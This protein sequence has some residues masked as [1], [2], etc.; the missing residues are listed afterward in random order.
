MPPVGN[1][2]PTLDIAFELLKRELIADGEDLLDF[3]LLINDATTGEPFSGELLMVSEPSGVGQS[4]HRFPMSRSHVTQIGASGGTAGHD[5]RIGNI[6]PI[7][8]RHYKSKSYSNGGL[9]VS[10]W[11]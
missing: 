3:Q 8:T 1:D 6:S 2:L 10:G 9:S 11:E 5:L 4:S 7:I